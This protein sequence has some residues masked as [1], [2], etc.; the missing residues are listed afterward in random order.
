[1]HF[2]AVTVRLSAT[3]GK[4]SGGLLNCIDLLEPGDD[5]VPTGW[6]WGRYLHYVMSNFADGS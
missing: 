3:T 1:V 2:H 6:H 5:L 4:R